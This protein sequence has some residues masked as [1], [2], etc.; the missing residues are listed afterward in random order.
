MDS[1][2]FLQSVCIQL[3]EWRVSRPFLMLSAEQMGAAYLKGAVLNLSAP[4]T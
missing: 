4:S 1:L 3:G 2:L